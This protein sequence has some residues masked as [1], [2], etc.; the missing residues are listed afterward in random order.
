MYRSVSLIQASLPEARVLC[1]C[2]ASIAARGP[3]RFRM[4][5]GLE[6]VRLLVLLP[7]TITESPLAKGTDARDRRP[8]Q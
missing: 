6:P 4:A 7:R 1:H 2:A 3:S 5:G 8:T